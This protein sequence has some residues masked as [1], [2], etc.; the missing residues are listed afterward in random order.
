MI[1]VRVA[2]NAEGDPPGVGNPAVL[3]G[4]AF[5]QELISNYR[6]K[7]N[8]YDTA[9]MD[10]ADFCTSEPKFPASKAVWVN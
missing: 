5:G 9:S 4:K 1:Q 8:V 6:R 3:L 10:V 2:S 7:G